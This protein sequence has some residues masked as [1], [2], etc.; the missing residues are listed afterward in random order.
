MATPRKDKDEAEAVAE[1]PQA[2]LKDERPPLPTLEGDG[3]GQVD[4]KVNPA[5]DELQ[6]TV[7]TAEARGFLGVKADP[8]P[9]H[10]YAVEGVTQGLPTP[11]T[12]RG[13]G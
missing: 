9:N 13:Q 3:V 5:Q 2:V 7:D 1:A 8:T 4:E 11:E 10:H 6:E 12:E